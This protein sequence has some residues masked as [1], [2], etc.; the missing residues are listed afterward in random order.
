MHHDIGDIADGHFSLS[1]CNLLNTPFY[2]NSFMII[3]LCF[4]TFVSYQ[5]RKKK[6]KEESSSH[7]MSCFRLQDPM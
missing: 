4:S 1:V 7:C 5:Y 2:N 6:V 3:C